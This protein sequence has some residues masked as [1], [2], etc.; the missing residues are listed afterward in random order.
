MVLSF[1]AESPSSALRFATPEDTS[2]LRF[3]AILLL[4]E[5]AGGFRNVLD[6]VSVVGDSSWPPLPPIELNT[7]LRN[8]L[9]SQYPRYMARSED[10]VDSH[11]CCQRSLPVERVSR[12]R[13]Y[14]R[15]LVGRSRVITC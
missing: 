13:Y 8:L 6:G 11:S 10:A 5:F 14:R 2:W 4:D 3:C 9:P 12:Y 15:W 1:G 7:E